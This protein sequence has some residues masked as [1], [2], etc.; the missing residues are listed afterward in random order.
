MFLA[1][2]CYSIMFKYLFKIMLVVVLFFEDDTG[3]YF[4]YLIPTSWTNC[5]LYY[6]RLCG[7]AISWNLCFT[8]FYC[9]PLV[10]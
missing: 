9:F 4:L 3:V 1:L 7:N 5:T 2:F 6:R 10:M 8:N